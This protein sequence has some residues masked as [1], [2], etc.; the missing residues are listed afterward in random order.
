MAHRLAHLGNNAVPHSPMP[1]TAMHAVWPLDG[2]DSIR[3]INAHMRL[4]ALC[5]MNETTAARAVAH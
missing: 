1:P 2:I 5:A 3:P 4:L